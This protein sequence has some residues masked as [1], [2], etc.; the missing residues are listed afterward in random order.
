[1]KLTKVKCAKCNKE[2]FI[3]EVF[4]KGICIDCYEK[5]FN[6]EVEKTGVLPKPDFMRA[7]K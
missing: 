7:L 1:M 6:K 3:I 2:V 5:E 4:P